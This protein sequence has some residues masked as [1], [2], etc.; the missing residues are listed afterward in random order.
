[1][2]RRRYPVC[3][4]L[5]HD[6]GSVK[7]KQLPTPGVDSAHAR[8]PW[9]RQEHLEH[10]PEARGSTDT[11]RYRLSP[12]QLGRTGPQILHASGRVSHNESV[13]ES[14]TEGTG[15]ALK[16]LTLRGFDKELERRLRHEAQVDG[17]SLNR[18]ALK[19][20]RRG[21]GLDSAVPSN[22]VGSGL[23][24]LIGTW[25]EFDERS[26]RNATAVFERVDEDF[27]R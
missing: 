19:L 10:L 27:W 26:L 20:I 7:K 5:G 11:L 9:R 21:A 16:Q 14:S 17:V 24:H 8:S 18:A 3:S 25:S 23:D 4:L 2:A 1:V 13:N 12:R 22:A 15:V 6:A